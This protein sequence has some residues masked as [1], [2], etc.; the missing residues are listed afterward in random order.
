MKLYDSYESLS[1]DSSKGGSPSDND[2]D[3]MSSSPSL[4]DFF[5]TLTILNLSSFYEEA[6]NI[7]S[8]CIEDD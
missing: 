1:N 8:V 7:D 2:I 3:L 5:M 4:N 6:I